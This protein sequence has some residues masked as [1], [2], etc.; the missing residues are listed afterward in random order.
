LTAPTT[1]SRRARRLASGAQLYVLNRAG[2]LQLR[3]PELENEI[4]SQDADLAIRRSIEEAADVEG[5]AEAK[6]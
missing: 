4:T 6:S 2:W 5:S 1:P 3:E